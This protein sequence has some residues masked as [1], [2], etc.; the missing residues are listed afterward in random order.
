MAGKRNATSELNHDNWEE[1]EPEEAGTFKRASQDVLRGRVIKT[2]K[3][4]NPISSDNENKTKNVFSSFGGFGKTT[5]T[6]QGSS[7]AFAFLTNSTANNTNGLSSTTSISSSTSPANSI[8]MF[9]MPTNNTVNSSTIG[10]EAK[11]ND[12]P[13]SYYAK[14]KGLNESVSQWIKTHVDKNPFCILTPIFK[15]YEK[16]LSEIESEKGDATEKNT[17][18]DTTDSKLSNE[19]K[20]TQITSHSSSIFGNSM[21]KTNENPFLTKPVTSEENPK[22]SSTNT[23]SSSVSTSTFTFGN[24]S[25]TTTA[26]STVG[27]SFGSGT[28]FKFTNVAKPPTEE[29]KSEEKDEEDEPPKVE[30]KPVVEDGS[31]FSKRCKVFVKKD[32]AFGDR[33]VGQL[34]LK[35]V[36]GSEKIQLIVRADTNLGNLLLNFILSDGIPIQRTGKNNVMLV[37]IPTPEAKPPPTPILLRVKTAEEADELLKVLEKNKK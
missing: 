1:Y 29:T 24:A 13:A 37:C 35:P 3:R 16:Y 36:A 7:T 34:F 30:F 28:P 22:E 18:S 19:P 23:V 12:K 27:F 6:N 8:S 25:N 11:K 33:G 14:L 17:N 31:I 9:K 32:G 4:R 2:A 5:T 26:S 15:D 21:S 10:A 20:T